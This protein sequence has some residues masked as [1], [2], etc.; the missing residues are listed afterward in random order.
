[1]TNLQFLRFRIPDKDSNNQTFTDDELNELIKLNSSVQVLKCEQLDIERKIF[2]IPAIRLDETYQDRVFV[3]ETLNAKKEVTS[4]FTIDKETGT[5]T[6]D[7]GVADNQYVFVQTKMIDWNNVLADAYE[8]ILSDLQKLQNFTIQ[9]V[10][11][12]GGGDSYDIKRHL[13]YLANYYRTP[14]TGEL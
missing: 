7:E 4:G 12:N 14:I 10:S 5:L 1:M 6:F 9:N 2:N 11:V 13:R 8:I 3:G